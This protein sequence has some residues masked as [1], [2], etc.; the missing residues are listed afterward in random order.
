MAAAKPQ[1]LGQQILYEELSC[2][3][4]LE[5]FTRPKLLPCGHTFCQDCLQVYFCESQD[6]LKCPNCQLQVSLPPEGVTGLP[7]NHSAAKFCEKL[8]KTDANA[9]K[10][11]KPRNKCSQHPSEDYQLYCTQCDVP[12]CYVC[13]EETHDGHSMT[14]L[15]KATKE[16]KPVVQTLLKEGK[17]ILGTYHDAL[18][19]MREKEKR[20][21][22]QKKQT[23]RDI[24]EA[25]ERTLKEFERTANRLRLRVQEKHNENTE[26]RQRQMES[27]QREVDE[28]AAACDQAE[29]E[30]AQGGVTF[31]EREDRLTEVIE[32]HR[33]APLPPPLRT[34]VI[35]FHPKNFENMP[36]PLGDIVIGASAAVSKGK[37]D[38]QGNQ[39]QGQGEER[40]TFGG[41]GSDERH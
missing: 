29:Q 31:L 25:Y 19:D 14:S 33:G 10:Q 9:D 13:L 11:A 1:S 18:K 4:C 41:Q 12:V 37:G 15:K 35:A 36:E 38:H 7:E 30:M 34:Q 27:V 8:S 28:L 20:L 5:L 17:E 16:R 32:K 26:A 21:I 3:I 39:G 23:E 24:I 2:S 6:H 22:E 40:L